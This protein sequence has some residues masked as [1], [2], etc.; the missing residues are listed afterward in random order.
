MTRKISPQTSLEN[1]KKEAKRF[2]KA[3]RAGDA[4]ALANFH[5][6]YPDAPAKPGLRD[7]QHAIALHF[8]MTGWTELKKALAQRPPA[9]ESAVATLPADTPE[10]RVAQFL[11]FAC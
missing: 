11:E 1:L 3:L 7:V 10:R 2:L 9:A 8:G 5:R 4:E 6:K